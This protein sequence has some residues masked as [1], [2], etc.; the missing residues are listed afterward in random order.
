MMVI[1]EKASI[2]EIMKRCDKEKIAELILCKSAVQFK[3]QA[4]LMGIMLTLPEAQKVQETLSIM[5][6]KTQF[7]S[8][9]EDEPFGGNVNS[10]LAK[11]F[12]KFGL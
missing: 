11:A 4:S 8:N 6:G 10:D 7:L 1:G 3:Y 5:R 2:D 9:L 12:S